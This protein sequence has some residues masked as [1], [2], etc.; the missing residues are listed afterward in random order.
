MEA[1]SL[2][3]SKKRKLPAAEAQDSK[4]LAKLDH[5]DDADDD[6]SKITTCIQESKNIKVAAFSHVVRVQVSES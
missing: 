4:K 1:H 3:T 5:N 2:H 6:D